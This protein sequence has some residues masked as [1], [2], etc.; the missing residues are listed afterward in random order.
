MQSLFRVCLHAQTF[1][2]V[3]RRLS[4]TGVKESNSSG[5]G[6]QDLLPH[7]FPLS[8]LSP[9]LLHPLHH[10]VSPMHRLPGDSCERHYVVL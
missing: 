9:L 4:T 5:G 6:P 2:C 8:R 3:Q 1:P 10:T 7:L